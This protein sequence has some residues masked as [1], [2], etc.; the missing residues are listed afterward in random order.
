MS[1]P[2][3]KIKKIQLPGDV[4][5]NK[6]YE[7]IPGRLQNSGYEAALPTLTADSVLALTS[8]LPTNY[9]TTNTSQTVSGAKTF[10]ATDTYI[11]NCGFSKSNNL[12]S[13]TCPAAM[14]GLGS[15]P[16]FGLRCG[17]TNYYLQ[18]TSSGLFLGPTSSVA[19]S[20][21]SNGDMTVR[22]TNQPKWNSKT[23]ATTDQLPTVNNATLTIT[24]GGVSKGTFT[25]NASS[26]VT[27]ALDA[28]GAG[29]YNDLDN[30]PIENI[31]G[32]SAAFNTG[33]TLINGDKIY[34]NTS[35]TTEMADFLTNLNYTLE[36]GVVEYLVYG[37][38]RFD[39]F[40]YNLTSMS[41]GY[42]I[43]LNDYY[44][45]SR[46]STIIYGTTSGEIP[47]EMTW[48]Q[49]W[50]NLAADG[51]F[52]LSLRN[53]E[54]L[55]VGEA[56]GWNGTLIGKSSNWVSYEN[57]VY[58]KTGGIIYRCIDGVLKKV[59]NEGDVGGVLDGGSMNSYYNLIANG[60]TSYTMPTSVFNT[61]NNNKDKNYI[62]RVTGSYSG[63][64]GYFYFRAVGIADTDNDEIQL[65]PI[66][67][68]SYAY[69]L[70]GS[71]TA[72]SLTKTL[73][74]ASTGIDD[75][76][77]HSNKSVLDDISTQTAYTSK[78]TSTKVPTITT[79]T[80][81]QVT[82]ISETNIS[83]PVTDIQV[84]SSSILSSGTANLVTNSAYNSSSNKIA[85]MND[86]PSS[87]TLTATTGSEAIA[88]SSNSINVMTR[89]TAQTIT[90]FKTFNA[91]TNIAGTEQ[92][93]VKLKT[94]N[95]GAII[96]GKE[97][98]NSGSMI[99]LDQTD[100]TCRLR[101]RSSA[102][103]GAMVWEQPEAG[104]RL[105]MDFKDSSSNTY[106]VSSPTVAGTIAVTGAS[107]QTGSFYAT[108]IYA[109]S[110]ERLK[111]NIKPAELDCGQVIDKLQ[112]KEFNFKADKDKKVVVGA[113][114]QELK[115]ILPE[116]YQAELVSGSED[117][118]YSINEGKLLYLAIGALK[119]ER[120]KTK[121]LEERISRL[122]KLMEE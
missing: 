53:T 13:D 43:L 95:G 76:H 60:S 25:A 90:G 7:V 119:E 110:D 83:F 89:D 77:T 88:D 31:S 69:Y 80:S 3:N 2:T 70:S 58:Y 97:G 42:V 115:V 24:Q 26:D 17:S 15:N 29:D 85:T 71:F 62:V 46:R 108:N 105:Y 122:E 19:T 1:L 72:S 27:I 57:G 32:A 41:L 86:L 18:A 112:I 98:P 99:R 38:D 28:G 93:T 111:E 104:S 94:S 116:K 9:V 65:S 81:G 63:Q 48:N 40:A 12:L 21:A 30:I 36:G 118:Q 4:E 34:F 92:Q 68:D 11:S 52:T 49:G 82:S 67:G 79:N 56:S 39:L 64:T 66:L 37:T 107:G 33:D 14:R 113:I 103:A 96:F 73:Y 117:T 5:G 35:K 87:V 120:Q 109:S 100:G 10:S 6:T 16:F 61:I 84:N 74:L 45:S 8:D 50:N 91:P 75:L 47:G 78:G 55:T 22:G 51:S 44:N 20:W 101:F 114:A 106:R 59:L 102:T 54:T 23:L 121:E